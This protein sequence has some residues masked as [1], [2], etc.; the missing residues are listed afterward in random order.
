MLGLNMSCSSKPT[1][2]LVWPVRIK[3]LYTGWVGG[4]GDE[5]GGVGCSRYMDFLYYNPQL[6]F[7]PFMFILFALADFMWCH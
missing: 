5:I 3:K 4:L 1:V 2:A 6:T 7:I